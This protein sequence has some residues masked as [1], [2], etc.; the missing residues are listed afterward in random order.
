MLSWGLGLSFMGFWA[1]FGLEPCPNRVENVRLQYQY[2]CSLRGVCQD[3]GLPGPPPPP[4]PQV[5][6]LWSSI[7]GTSGKKEGSGGV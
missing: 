7:V 1:H 4:P 2:G 6:P 3:S 5:E